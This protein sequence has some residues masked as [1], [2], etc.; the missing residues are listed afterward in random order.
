MS[1]D[2]KQ[3]FKSASKSILQQKILWSLDPTERLVFH[4]TCIGLCQYKPWLTLAYYNLILTSR[5]KD[6]APYS[7]SS[8]AENTLPFC[9]EA[10]KVNRFLL[11]Y[12]NNWRTTQ[13]NGE[14]CFLISVAGNCEVRH[15][16]LSITYW[17]NVIS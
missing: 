15:K 8:K 11:L 13:H 16:P 10:V 6:S 3:Q 1:H 2:D 12:F 5:Y 4:L 17:H 14:L 7:E 9:L